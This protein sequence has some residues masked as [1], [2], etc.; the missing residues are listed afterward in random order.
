MLVYVVDSRMEHLDEIHKQDQCS[1][2]SS[3]QKFSERH[4]GEHHRVLTFTYHAL[5]LFI[6]M[7]GGLLYLVLHRFYYYVESGKLLRRVIALKFLILDFPQQVFIVAYIYGW[8]ATNGLRCQM[9]LF[10]PLHCETQHPL[11]W[12]NLLACLFT[13]LSASA[14]QMMLEA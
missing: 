4:N 13:I 3:W 8:Y 11:H 7:S 2:E 9:C 5:T 10:H 14:N 1:F 6:I 12:S